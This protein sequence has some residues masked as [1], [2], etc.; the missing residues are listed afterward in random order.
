[1]KNLSKYLSIIV[2]PVIELLGDSEARVRYYTCESLYNI[3]KVARGDMLRYFNE[4]FNGLCTLYMDQDDPEVRN[5]AQLLD[6]LMKDVVAETDTFDVNKF[7]PTL[8]D[9]LKNPKPHVRQLLVSWILLLDT[10]PDID[11]LEHLPKFLDGL[12]DFLEDPLH[13][14]QAQAKNALNE[15]L[16]EIEG[17]LHVE[18]GPMVR[19]LVNICKNTKRQPTCRLTALNWICEFIKLGLQKLAPFYPDMLEAILVCIPKKANTLTIINKADSTSHELLSLVSETAATSPNLDVRKLK[20]VLVEGL[21]SEWEETRIVSLNWVSML[22]MKVPLK[23]LDINDIFPVLLKLLSDESDDVV[24]N[25]LEVMAR[26]SANPNYFQLVLRNLLDVFREPKGDLLAKRGKMII[27]RFAELLNGRKIYRALA[28][29]VAN[30]KDMRF[31]SLMVQTL[32]IILLTS[33]E[34]FELREDIK[35]SLH[36]NSKDEQDLFTTLFKTWCF[37]PIATLSLCLTAQAYELASALVLNLL[38]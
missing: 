5:G 22:L 28:Q 25:D 35:K 38:I 7:I 27:E 13:D 21:E 8:Q 37:D 16:R 20:D 19:I 33:P 36:S 15:F 17:S 6:R 2:P 4:I 31:A 24:G 14:I 10:V 26:I 12:F 23:E 29:E 32:N 30:E 1:M 18:Y 3:T 34:L 11:M 9:L